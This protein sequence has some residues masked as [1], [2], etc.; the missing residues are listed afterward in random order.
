M[1]TLNYSKL[2]PIVALLIYSSCQSKVSV[3]SSDYNRKLVLQWQEIWNT[4]KTD[5]LSEVITSDF[6][7][8]Y[9][10]D[11]EWRG[12]EGAKTEITN[13]RKLF[14]DWHEEVLD[15]II[16]KDKVVIRYNSTGTHSGHTR[17]LIPLGRRS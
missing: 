10:T 1:K 9:L 17:V 11:G 7:C 5:K 2:I 8:H 16:E 3:D 6:V 12:V 14:P 15:F 13:W 4:G